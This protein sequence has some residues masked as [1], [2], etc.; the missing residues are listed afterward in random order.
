MIASLVAPEA[1]WACPG[2]ASQRSEALSIPT[3]FQ[4]FTVRA[5]EARL[6]GYIAQQCAAFG[7]NA[8]KI[9]SEFGYRISPAVSGA[10]NIQFETAFDDPSVVLSDD[11]I[12]DVPCSITY[13]KDRSGGCRRYRASID[14]IKRT[15]MLRRT[16]RGPGGAPDPAPHVIIN[17]SRKTSG[18]TSVGRLIELHSVL[19]VRLAA[20][21]KNDIQTGARDHDEEVIVSDIGIGDKAAPTTFELARIA[22]AAFDTAGLNNIKIRIVGVDNYPGAVSAASGSE[23]NRLLPPG[24]R[25]QFILQDRFDLSEAGLSR[26]DM[27]ICANALSHYYTLADADAALKNIGRAMR[28]G[29]LI[30]IASGSE[31]SA[32]FD[33]FSSLGVKVEH[34]ISKEHLTGEALAISRKFRDGPNAGPKTCRDFF[35][36]I[37]V[38]EKYI[39][40]KLLGSATLPQLV[41]TWDYLTGDP[42]ETITVNGVN[43]NKLGIPGNNPKKLLSMLTFG[44]ESNIAPTWEFLVEQAGIPADFIRRN[45]Q[46]LI[47]SLDGQNNPGS[48]MRMRTAYF[49]KT[50][51]EYASRPTIIMETFARLGGYSK[52]ASDRAKVNI[53]DMEEFR[54]SV[55][56]P[57]EA[58]IRYIHSRIGKKMTD[59]DQRHALLLDFRKLRVYLDGYLYFGGERELLEGQIRHIG[60]RYASYIARLR[61]GGRMMEDLHAFERLLPDM[62]VE[63]ATGRLADTARVTDVRQV[64]LELLTKTFGIDIAKADDKRILLWSKR[65]LEDTWEYLTGSPAETITIDQAVYHKLGI[66]PKAIRTKPFILAASVSDRIN[67]VWELLVDQLGIPVDYVRRNPY[68]LLSSLDGIDRECSGLRMRAAYLTLKKRPFAAR[69]T[70]LFTTPTRLREIYGVDVKH[71]E[72]FRTEFWRPREEAINK[73]HAMILSGVPKEEL[74]RKALKMEFR[75][76]RQ[77]LD[78]YQ[79][80]HGDI[81]AL[82]TQAGKIIRD[83]IGR[84]KDQPARAAAL[85][86]MQ[87]ILPYVEPEPP[88]KQQKPGKV[89]MRTPREILEKA[90]EL[91]GGRKYGLLSALVGKMRAAEERNV[92]KD[93]DVREE[94]DSLVEE[95]MA[96]RKRITDQAVYY[97]IDEEEYVVGDAYLS[98][99]EME[100]IVIVKTYSEMAKNVRTIADHDRSSVPE[101]SFNAYEVAAH[102]L[103]L[104]LSKDREG[105]RAALTAMMLDPDN[106]DLMRR[107]YEMHGRDRAGRIIMETLG[108]KP[109]DAD[110]EEDDGTGPVSDEGDG[111]VLPIDTTKKPSLGNIRE[112]RVLVK[113]LI[114][115]VISILMS[116]DGRGAEPGNIKARKLVLVFHEGIVG[117]KDD[118]LGK[119]IKGI[120]TLKRKQ[121]FDKLL[122]DLIIIRSVDKFRTRTAPAGDIK[123][124]DP[125][126]VA[127]LFASQAD[128]KELSDIS[129]N[130]KQVLIADGKGNSKPFDAETYYY[131][132]AEIVTLALISYHRAMSPDDAR[133][134]LVENSVDTEKLNFQ[135]LPKDPNDSAFLVFKLI[136]TIKRDGTDGLDRTKSILNAIQAAA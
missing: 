93:D 80:Y 108:I 79:Y 27:A 136:G 29:G 120:E 90:R 62:H 40:K 114:E 28:P 59:P 4:P 52:S 109:G 13:Q 3:L 121:G 49:R 53:E 112:S 82:T 26:I 101:R 64:K 116:W 50:G 102:R 2:P 38:P 81:K 135:L 111:D 45:P 6:E 117:L 68:V 132:L 54:K 92:M 48:G 84:I 63:Y 115:A 37:G 35:V 11:G 43:Y 89:K 67:P 41:R 22:R 126:T 34:G 65:H 16:A 17:L 14:T 129:S 30:A 55:W 134:A 95:A 7:W 86:V 36:S 73:A 122:K 39:T 94:L 57:R 23:E 69:P 131:P 24:V 119:V 10:L 46:M 19:M 97:D 9:R 110:I 33:L 61:E 127:F 106:L 66:P 72:R 25:M 113:N 133:A 44:I 85:A 77:S 12:L 100:R 56:A 96:N 1:A 32:V 78:A 42:G 118:K 88:A 47:L 18:D 75:R 71:M 83:Y 74:D 98:D 15:I 20:S 8:E 58:R 104:L 91:A 107:F 99:E 51:I 70:V 130:V 124:E 105:L 5:L 123:L 31:G 60:T 76:F 125:N 21:I 87:G 103:T 128:R